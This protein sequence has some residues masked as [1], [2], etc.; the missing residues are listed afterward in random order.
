LKQ[1]G[2]H[3][4]SCGENLGFKHGEIYKFF[5]FFHFSIPQESQVSKLK[6]LGFLCKFL[7]LS[8][9]IAEFFLFQVSK[10]KKNASNFKKNIML[11]F[12]TCSACC[13]SYCLMFQCLFCKFLF[14]LFYVSYHFLH[15]SFCFILCFKTCILCFSSTFQFF[16]QNIVNM[17]VDQF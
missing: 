5:S 16:L 12:N 8:F 6:S 1:L 11:C 4:F 2:S 17:Q 9:Y 7:L 3:Y 10:P 15:I 14:T 13:F